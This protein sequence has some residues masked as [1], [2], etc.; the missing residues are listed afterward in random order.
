[1]VR[2]EPSATFRQISRSVWFNFSATV[3]LSISC[4]Q[5][6][7]EC[8]SIL[9]GQI[10]GEEVGMVNVG[11]ALREKDTFKRA[12]M[13]CD[14]AATI[15]CKKFIT[16]KDIVEVLQVYLVLRGEGVPAPHFRCFPMQGNP[17]LNLAFVATL[18]LAYPNMYVRDYPP[19]HGPSIVIELAT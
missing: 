13:V 16:A 14:M 1:M 18:Y 10:A 17:R 8:Y 11:R 3:N 19:T 4:H 5:Q 2:P 15:K 7:A 6:D 12:Q 9:L